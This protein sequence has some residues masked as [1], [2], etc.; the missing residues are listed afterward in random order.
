MAGMIGADFRR[1]TEIGRKKR[2]AHLPCTT[3][4]RKG[5]DTRRPGG[6]KPPLQKALRATRAGGRPAACTRGIV[7][8]RPKPGEVRGALRLEPGPAWGR[9]AP[10]A[11]TVNKS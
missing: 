5:G 2:R 6:D 7:T 1:Q 3:S 10:L 8:V 9:N 4:G 11:K